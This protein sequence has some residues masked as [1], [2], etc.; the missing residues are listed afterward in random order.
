MGQYI[1][2][3]TPEQ[4]K[5]LLTDMLSIQ[6]W[7]ENAITNKARQC[8]DQIVNDEIK[9][10]QDDPSITTIPADKNEIIK[11]AEVKTAAEKQAEFE[12]GQK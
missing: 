4:E 6:D 3:L 1:I 8:T 7:I 9:R 5:A 10:M 11:N 12:A 2:T